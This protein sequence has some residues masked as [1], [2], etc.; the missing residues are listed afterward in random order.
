MW[1]GYTE[2]ARKKPGHNTNFGHSRGKRP[3]HPRL[4]A[5]P[6]LVSMDGES[7]INEGRGSSEYGG[8]WGSLSIDMRTLGAFVDRFCFLTMPFLAIASL[9]K[10]LAMT[11]DEG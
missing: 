8:C 2:H 5:E 7:I 10:L 1:E 9:P 6:A 11:E 3:V 4:S